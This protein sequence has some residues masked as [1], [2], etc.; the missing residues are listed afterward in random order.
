MEKSIVT[1]GTVLNT[2]EQSQIH[3]GNTSTTQS[4][5]VTFIGNWGATFNQDLTVPGE[6]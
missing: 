2:T 6:Q 4:S 3:G 1:I 5:N